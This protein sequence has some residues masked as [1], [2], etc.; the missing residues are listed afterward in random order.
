MTVLVGGLTGLALGV[1]GAQVDVFRF[2]Q[3]FQVRYGARAATQVAGNIIERR[4]LRW[5][6]SRRTP[7]WLK[8]LVVMEAPS[9]WAAVS[10]VVRAWSLGVELGRA[11]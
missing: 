11:S 8:R 7:T 9:P 10:T 4:G 6:S 2:I 5:P 3:A 1:S